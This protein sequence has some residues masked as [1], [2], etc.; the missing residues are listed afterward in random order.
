MAENTELK[1]ALIAERTLSL[2][3]THIVIIYVSGIC[4]YHIHRYDAC[5]GA[6]QRLEDAKEVCKSAMRDLLE[7]GID[8]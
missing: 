7:M 3:G 4:P 6:A 2:L 1:W 5:L 8:P